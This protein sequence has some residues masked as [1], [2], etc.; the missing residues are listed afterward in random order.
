MYRF[1]TV[2]FML[3][4]IFIMM[5]LPGCNKEK[6]E[7]IKV[8]AMQ[9]RIEAIDALN[10][11]RY[12]F[13]QS[14]SLPP[15]NQYQQTNRIA[16]DLDQAENIGSAELSFL[17]T[18]NKVNESSLQ[19][20]SNEFKTLE[21]QYYQFESMFQSLPEGSFFAKNAVKKSEK[22]AIQLTVQFINI[23]K[24]LQTYDPQFTGRRV[25]LLEKISKYKSIA[26]DSLRH[27][28]L[29]IAAQEIIELRNEEN[30]AREEAITQCFRAVEAGKLISDLI[31]NY[32]KM[33]V[34]DLLTTTRN[35][36]DYISNI[37]PEW[38]DISTIKNRLDSTE[39]TI[40]NDPYWKNL[41]NLEII[42]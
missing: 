37:S 13:E 19:Q 29:R 12:L 6:A 16:V 33:S 40:Q 18:E 35:T 30:L 7:A 3:L 27:S 23:A 39:N 34:Q 36:L 22:F 9:F 8:A 21:S 28:Y 26:D 11:V 4:F 32:S 38:K 10:K 2:R 24:F 41:L 15:E 14:V 17:I 20:I 42:N 1:K 5:I 25:L 31:R